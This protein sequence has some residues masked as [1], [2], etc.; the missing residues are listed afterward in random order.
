VTAT[1][2]KSCRDQKSVPTLQL[3]IQMPQVLPL[4]SIQPFVR[5]QASKPDALDMIPASLAEAMGEVRLG[6]EKGLKPMLT[7][8]GTSG[9]YI[10][11]GQDQEPIGV[12]KPIDE[13]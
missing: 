10:L 6:F 9:T 8:E 4:N 1:S 12:F 2:T 11:R 3:T 5:P 7:D 13:E